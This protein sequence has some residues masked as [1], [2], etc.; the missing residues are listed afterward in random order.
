MFLPFF[1]LAQPDSG[2]VKI[3]LDVLGTEDLSKTQVITENTLTLA[4]RLPEDIH[5]IPFTAFIITKEQIQNRGYATLVDVLK[6]LPGIK[7][8]QPGSAVHGE[9]FLMRG[10][11]GNYY[12]KILVDDLPMQPSA[13][14]GMPIGAQ[15]PI[16][17]AERIEVLYGPAAA[18]YGADAMAGVINIVT[19]KST[20][21][22]MLQADVAVGLPGNIKFDASIGGK[23]GKSNKVWNYMLFGGFYQFGNM[24]ITGSKYTEEYNPSNY[25]PGGDEGIYL[26]SPYYKG[27]ETQPAFSFLPQQSQ[28]MGLRFGTKKLTFGADFSQRTTHSAIGS[29]PIYKLY[30]DPNTTFGERMVRVFGSYKTNLGKWFS[31]T[32]LQL[33]TYT[34]NPGSNYITIDN[35]TSFEGR[36]YQYGASTD[37]YLEQFFSTTIGAHWTVLAG[38][39]AQFS[40]NL[41][42][43]DFYDAPFKPSAYTMFGS[44]ATGY[45][46]LDSLG[47]GPYNFLTLGGIVDVNYKHEKWNF[48]VGVRA[49]YREFYGLALN[50][51][52]GIVLKPNSK[53]RI[54]FTTST[55][56]RPPSSY[57][58]YSGV[59]AYQVGGVKFGLPTANNNLG[60]EHLL[61]FDAGWAVLLS[62]N[63]TLDFSAFYHINKNLITRTTSY[64]MVN[65]QEKEY[66]GYVND[67][68]ASARLLGLQVAH[69]VQFNWGNLP[70][71]SDASAQVAK[72]SEVLPFDRGSLS[73]YRMQPVTTVK[74]LIEAEPMAHLYA[75]IRTQFFS[76]WRTRSVVVVGLGDELVAPSFYTI[77]VQLRYSFSEGKQVY[78]M[79]NNVMNTGY[80]GIGAS[81]GAGVLNNRVVFED[82]SF[83]PQLLRVVKV[84]VK[85]NI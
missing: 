85:I 84:G 47:L 19:R 82:L 21:L 3:P 69:R 51:R 20:Q 66:Y 12:V 31:Q 33:L 10:L 29:N 17:Q 80:Y 59:Q 7:V 16:A 63:H 8:S 35:P 61:S 68:S 53:N 55:A 42:Q 83:N 32:N 58:I 34:I 73:N 57:L 45:E 37:L 38:A 41:P 2:S 5:E 76:D 79:V 54:R 74:W 75:S 50:P 71:S 60:A 70:I 26:N 62:K 52:M 67:E 43:F 18:I 64:T 14:S 13:T 72:G 81:G 40:G 46:Y 30:H 28:K 23:F 9:T 49:D 1:A 11:F 36:F 27:T 56:Y 39:T 15:L 22:Q 24:P 65:G 25:V 4:G 48:L 6:D 78:V 77:D 44:S